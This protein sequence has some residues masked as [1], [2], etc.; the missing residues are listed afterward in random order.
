MKNYIPSLVTMKKWHTK[1]RNFQTGDRV[2][3]CDPNI[4]RGQWRIG[5]IYA[6]HLGKDSNVRVADVRI[7]TT[8]YRR[9]IHRLCLSEENSTPAVRGRGA[10]CG[11]DKDRRAIT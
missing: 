10:C 8:D 6:L 2:I 9:P 11:G 4:P 3:I 1:K 7:E 5:L